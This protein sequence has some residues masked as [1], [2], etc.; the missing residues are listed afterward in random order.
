MCISPIM[1]T[2]EP[3]PWVVFAV[4]Q[5]EPVLAL[6][7]EGSPAS[8]SRPYNRPE[9]T[10]AHGSGSGSQAQTIMAARRF[11]VGEDRAGCPPK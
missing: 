10:S 9:S 2:I 6:T 3:V 7:C 5:E 1:L 8:R 4:G 11:I